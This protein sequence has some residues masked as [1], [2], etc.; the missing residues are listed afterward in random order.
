MAKRMIQ[1]I[2]SWNSAPEIGMVVVS[3]ES[4]A[5]PVP[6]AK[7]EAELSVQCFGAV[8]PAADLC[9]KAQDQRV[10]ALLLQPESVFGQNIISMANRMFPAHA[11][12]P[13]SHGNPSSIRRI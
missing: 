6:I 9:V 2:R 5:S 8:P 10:P 7:I 4:L 3:R 13:V 1:V 12:T 11:A